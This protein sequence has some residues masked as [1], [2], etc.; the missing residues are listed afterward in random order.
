MDAGYLVHCWL[1]GAMGEGALKPWTLVFSEG[2]VVR[3]LG[4]TTWTLQRLREHAALYST[5]EEASAIDWDAVRSKQMPALSPGLRVGVRVRFVP[6]VRL[7]SGERDLF[8]V[9]GRGQTREQVY[10]RWLRERLLALG[11]EQVS[12]LQVEQ[13]GRCRTLRR[14]QG[15]VRHD[16]VISLPS[17]LMSATITVGPGGADAL[18]RRGVGRHRAFGFGMALLSPPR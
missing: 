5:P 3:V 1:T 9:D 4:Y 17:V 14:T 18:I 2:D 13:I 16:R 12:D 15:V 7:P 6:T 11:A 10:G 8:E